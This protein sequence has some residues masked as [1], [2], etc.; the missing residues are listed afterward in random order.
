MITPTIGRIVWF[1]PAKGDA[2]LDFGGQKLPGVV[3][4]V[5][6]DGMVNLAVFNSNGASFGRT[7]VKLLQ[8]DEVGS[9]SG[10]YAEWM[11]YQKQVAASR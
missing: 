4:Y 7:S 6:S 8:D 10:Y 9:E 11:P 5:H 3:S 2:D 1:T